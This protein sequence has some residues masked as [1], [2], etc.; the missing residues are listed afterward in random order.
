MTLPM[1]IDELFRI[2]PARQE[3]AIDIAAEMEIWERELADLPLALLEGTS[4]AFMR[5]D[6]GRNDDGKHWRP[7]LPA[8]RQAAIKRRGDPPVLG[9]PLFLPEP[10]RQVSPGE[11]DRAIKLMTDCTASIRAATAAMEAPF[12]KDP[13]RLPRE[14]DQNQPLPALSEEARKLFEI[15]GDDER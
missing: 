6:L 12:R 1:I 11:R 15:G 4:R 14:M 3:G 10:E 9:Y 5:G 2:L 7:T 8:F 13:P